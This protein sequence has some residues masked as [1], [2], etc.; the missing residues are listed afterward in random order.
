MDTWVGKIFK[1]GCFEVEFYGA[2]NKEHDSLDVDY[3]EGNGY[4][5]SSG[6]TSL[7]D[8][9]L[10]EFLNECARFKAWRDSRKPT[11]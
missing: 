10:D 4:G 8:E 6:S 9:E 1:S 11:P 7:Y 2:M 3:D 5:C